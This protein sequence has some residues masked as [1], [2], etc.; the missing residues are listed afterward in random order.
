MGVGGQ[1]HAPAALHPEKRPG[2]HCIGGWIWT[3]AEN[4][5]PTGIRSPDRP[6]RSESPRYPG[7]HKTSLG[8]TAAAVS[9]SMSHTLLGR[10][11]SFVQRL[12]G[13]QL[14]GLPW[15][16]QSCRGCCE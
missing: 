13:P 8:R 9:L 2:T 10:S 7:P 14:F 6:A 15:T 12:T 4:L 11:T 5:A 3:A 1:R 16:V